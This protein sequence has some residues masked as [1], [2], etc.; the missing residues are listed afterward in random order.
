MGKSAVP[1]DVAAMP[2]GLA[3]GLAVLAAYVSLFPGL[4]FLTPPRRCAPVLPHGTAVGMLRLAL[5]AL[6]CTFS[7]IAAAVGSDCATF[8]ESSAGW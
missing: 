6:R 4:F 3:D 1:D 8:Q 2:Q 7:L 5:Y